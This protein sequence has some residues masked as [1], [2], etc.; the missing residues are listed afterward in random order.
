MGN[1]PGCATIWIG[2]IA[3]NNAHA[4]SNGKRYPLVIGE[5]DRATGLLRRRTVTPVADRPP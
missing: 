1:S 4:Y 5:V 3:P 2:N